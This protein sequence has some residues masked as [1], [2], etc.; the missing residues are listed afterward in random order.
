MT[1]QKASVKTTPNKTNRRTYNSPLRERQAAETRQS[2][3]DAGVEL[4]HEIPNWDWKNL[5]FRAVG[6]R[7]GISERTVYRHFSTERI[8]KDAIM[9][10]L[11]DTAGVDL[12][13]MELEDFP[14]ITGVVYEFLASVASRQEE[15]TDPT[16]ASID[17][18]RRL[19]LLDAVIR[20]TPNWSEAEQENAA[21]LLDI[22]WN[23]P[24]FERLSHLWRF[25]T[26]RSI[27]IVGWLIRLVEE[28][29]KKDRRP[30]SQD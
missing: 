30:T 11:V 29:I 26:K 2:I 19:A 21:A 9:R 25:D 15:E 12:S 10:Q 18:H 13:T 23:L 16:F 24:P 3:I 8:L 22:L 17:E 4:I 14:E 7:A 28:A 1:S 27:D 5:T 20:A 6:E